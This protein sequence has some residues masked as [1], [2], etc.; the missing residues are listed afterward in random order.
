MTPS[1]RPP[2]SRPL[3]KQAS[4]Q[5]KKKK[6]KKRVAEGQKESEQRATMGRAPTLP[7]GGPLLCVCFP[8]SHR[9]LS[10]DP[11]LITGKRTEQMFTLFFPVY[12]RVCVCVCVC[13]CIFAAFRFQS[14]R[15]HPSAA[16]WLSGNQHSFIGHYYLVSTVFFLPVWFEPGKRKGMFQGP[17][18]RLAEVVWESK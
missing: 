2:V 18:N 9:K 15:G 17:L 6:K 10:Y 16:V 5:K 14:A 13:V 8:V 4:K 12:V 1:V 7:F 11:Q 3:S